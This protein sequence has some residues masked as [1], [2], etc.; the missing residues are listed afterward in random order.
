MDAANYEYMLERLM[1]MNDRAGIDY[2]AAEEYSGAE[3]L[4][5]TLQNEI[6]MVEGT[7]KR[8]IRLLHKEG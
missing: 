3:A 1:D 8:I 7:V 5:D 2:L 6:E 4:L